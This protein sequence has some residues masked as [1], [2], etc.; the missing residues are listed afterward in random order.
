MADDKKTDGEGKEQVRKKGLPP[1]ILVA[2]GALLG[3]AGVVLGVPARPPETAKPVV[4][5][6]APVHHPD[7]LE[8][9][10]NPR[11]QAGR[12]HASVSFYFAYRVRED[13]KEAANR[14]I[15]ANWPRAYSMALELLRARTLIELNGD[16]G[17]SILA[18]DLVDVLD[19]A[20][21]PASKDGKLATVTEILWKEFLVH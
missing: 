18:K 5:S 4:H 17:Q 16:S 8:F 20:L 14:A 13:L 15:A 11:T 3:G 12:S 1:L 19:A 9:K 21:F 2:A 6:Y 7:L 10:F